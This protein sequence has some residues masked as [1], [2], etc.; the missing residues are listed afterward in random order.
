MFELR[1]LELW[2]GKTKHQYK[3]I[4]YNQSNSLQNIVLFFSAMYCKLLW[5]RFEV[6]I[7]HSDFYYTINSYEKKS[8]ISLKTYP[9][10]FNI[11]SKNTQYKGKNSKNKKRRTL[12]TAIVHLVDCDIKTLSLC[13]WVPLFFYLMYKQWKINVEV[14]T[15]HPLQLTQNTCIIAY[16]NKKP[17]CH[18]EWWL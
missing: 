15:C 11:L 1:P 17:S 6:E 10:Y 14:L 5:Q 16:C 9:V 13:V 3:G 8:H 18:D 12:I 7:N 2:I 4:S